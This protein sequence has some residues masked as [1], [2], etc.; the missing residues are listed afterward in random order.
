[1]STL[2]VDTIESKTLNGDITVSSPLSGSGASLTSLPAGN[3]TGT[4][5]DARISTLTASKL[6]G[7]LP[8][9]SGASLTN[10]PASGVTAY[11]MDGVYNF[12]STGTKTITGIGFQPTACLFMACGNSMDTASWCLIDDTSTAGSVTHMLKKLNTPAFSTRAGGKIYDLNI[13]V[14]RSQGVFTSFDSGGMTWSHAEAGTWSSGDALTY[15]VW[16]FK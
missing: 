2:K 5:A 8:A 10:L 12:G 6:T 13:G 15:V 11:T 4:V 9:I 14:N 16:L 1:M 3:L 7:A